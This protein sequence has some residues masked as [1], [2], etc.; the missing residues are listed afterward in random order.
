MKMGF[1]YSIKYKFGREQETGGGEIWND[2]FAGDGGIPGRMA[3]GLK[4][5]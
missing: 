1:F 2:R 5:E 4:D 3:K